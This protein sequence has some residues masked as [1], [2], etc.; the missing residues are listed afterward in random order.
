MRSDRCRWRRRRPKRVCRLGGGGLAGKPPDR[1]F[2]HHVDHGLVDADD[3]IAPRIVSGPVAAFRLP[4][5]PVAG[6]RIANPHDAAGEDALGLSDRLVGRIREIPVVYLGC[7]AGPLRQYTHRQRRR[8]HTSHDRC[9][10]HRY[11]RAAQQAHGP[12]EDDRRGDNAHQPDYE[13]PRQRR[14]ESS[15]RL[16]AASALEN[17][18]LPQKEMAS[19]G[20]TPG[21]RSRPLGPARRLIRKP[22]PTANAPPNATS[23]SKAVMFTTANLA[24][25]NGRS[26]RGL[27]IVL[28]KAK[29]PARR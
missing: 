23:P 18:D 22:P 3:V 11:A 15:G 10:R 7:S 14:A 27:V 16:K 12:M 5:A 21:Y 6:V 24:A 28:G 26:V 4:A 20:Y 17:N 19:C 13:V 29:N 1:V 25:A 9:T 8:E 2:H